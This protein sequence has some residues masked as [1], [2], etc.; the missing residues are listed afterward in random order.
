MLWL[1]L[2]HA[3]V[4]VRRLADDAL[5]LLILSVLGGL[6]GGTLT[7]VVIGVGATSGQ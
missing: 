7:V 2:L 5:I 6:V 1:H 3:I 4:H